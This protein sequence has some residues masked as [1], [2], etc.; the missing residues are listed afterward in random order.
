MDVELRHLRAFV[1]VATLRSFTAASRELLIGQPALTRTIQQLEASLG[2]RLLERT[3][4]AVDLTPAG[5]DVLVGARKVLH[6]L[7]ALIAT[8]RGEREVRVGFQ[9][10]LPDPWTTDTILAFERATGARVR[11]LRRDDIATALTDGE[12]DLALVRAPVDVGGYAEL[13]LCDERR[14]AAVSARSHLAGR[15]A[16][17]WSEVAKHPLVVNPVSGTT[18]LDQWPAEHRPRQVIECGSY[19][20]WAALVAADR[21]IG[22]TSD[23]AARTHAHAGIAYLPLHDAPPVTLRLVWQPRRADALVRQFA[24]IVTGR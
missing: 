1:A 19:D 8:A 22:T 3:S 17:D 21:G 24:S 12:I 5:Q 18:R 4:R 23:S 7:D 9:W 13:P 10:A 14:V 6:D 11:L 16:L 20:E 2:V 15:D